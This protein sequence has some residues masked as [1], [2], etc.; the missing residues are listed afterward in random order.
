MLFTV[1][2][3]NGIK[4]AF[5]PGTRRNPNVSY[6]ITLPGECEVQLGS[7]E[8]A[9]SVRA[10]QD[11]WAELERAWTKVG[12][13]STCQLE[14]RLRSMAEEI[15]RHPAYREMDLRVRYIRMPVKTT[16]TITV[17]AMPENTS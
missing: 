1:A 16:Q 15:A 5:G 2:L 8:M 12:A 6:F 14:T 10:R 7:Y 11:E 3:A 13:A 9:P 17:W 4:I